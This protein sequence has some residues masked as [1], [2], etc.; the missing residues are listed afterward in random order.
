MTL[1]VLCRNQRVLCQFENDRS[2]DA[3]R[4]EAID[5]PFMQI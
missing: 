3:L 4:L 5:P 1:K 2:C